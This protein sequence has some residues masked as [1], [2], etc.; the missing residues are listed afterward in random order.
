MS[1]NKKDSKKEKKRVWV[2]AVDHGELDN[3][4]AIFESK[5]EAFK[6]LEQKGLKAMTKSD[7]GYYHT[8][9]KLNKQGG[10]TGLFDMYYTRSYNGYYDLTLKKRPLNEQFVWQHNE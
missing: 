6:F 5:E 9:I 7:Y 2:L 1:D 10:V 8:K 3:V 4:I